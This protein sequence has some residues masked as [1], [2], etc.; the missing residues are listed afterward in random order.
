MEEDAGEERRPE[1]DGDPQTA[2]HPGQGHRLGQELHGD[3][4]AGAAERFA[5]ADLPRP[6]GDVDEHD[7]HHPDPADQER[8]AGDQ[9]HHRRDAAGDLLE[10]LELAVARED[11]E[12]VVLVGA[13][14][15]A[16]PEDRGLLGDQSV[17]VLRP[18]GDGRDVQAVA[19]AVLDL[20][21]QAVEGSQG[22][23]HQV[24]EAAAQERSLLHQET[25]HPEALAV[26][27]DLLVDG[28]A[29]G[30]EGI[31]HVGRDD[32]DPG[33]V[34]QPNELIKGSRASN[35]DDLMVKGG[36]AMDDIRREMAEIDKIRKTIDEGLLSKTNIANIEETFKKLKEAFAA[37]SPIDMFKALGP[38]GECL[39][40]VL[41][42]HGDLLK[43]MGSVEDG[44]KKGV[45]VV[46]DSLR[47]F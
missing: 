12:V 31:R 40:T 14:P 41:E 37:W 19:V 33:D 4:P 35:M 7:V 24:V 34:A 13:Q 17:V 44:I 39:I 16:A 18:L 27:R 10:A 32:G 38:A 45:E 47:E 26:D 28:I 15:P 11:G 29:V 6:L 3:V 21:E 9:H 2:A 5:E 8:D 30:E 42:K 36:L 22:Q 20:G 25:H 23:D 46:S 43:V 1:A